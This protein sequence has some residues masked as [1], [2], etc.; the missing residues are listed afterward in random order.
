MEARDCRRPEEPHGELVRAGSLQLYW[1]LLRP[2]PRRPKHNNCRRNRPEP[3]EHLR[4]PRGRPEF[5]VRCLI[6]PS[7]LEPL[8]WYHTLLVPRSQAALRVRRQQQ[9]ALGRV[10]DGRSR[11]TFTQVSRYSVQPVLWQHPNRSVRS[12]A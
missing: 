9:Q 6:V 10:P 5:A 2:R 12:Q 1:R 3:W 8:L 4:L 11:D 7:E